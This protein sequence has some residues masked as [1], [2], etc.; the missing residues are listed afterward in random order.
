MVAGRGGGGGGGQR[1]DLCN[2]FSG[3][4][5]TPPPAD[6]ALKNGCTILNRFLSLTFSVQGLSGPSEIS[7]NELKQEQQPANAV[8]PSVIRPSVRLPKKSRL[9]ESKKK[10]NALFRRDRGRSTAAEIAMMMLD[11]LATSAGAPKVS[12]RDAKLSP[13][14]IVKARH[15]AKHVAM[16]APAGSQDV[17]CP[18]V[19]AHD[20]S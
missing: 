7:L 3:E 19:R 8:H 2:V 1:Q 17:F 11:R 13:M 20:C 14:M 10:K 4:G 6:A 18:T 5:S 16:Q 12:A 15:P 9:Q